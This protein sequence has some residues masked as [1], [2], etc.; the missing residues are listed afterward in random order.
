MAHVTL[1][2]ADDGSNTIHG[3]SG[4]EVIYGFDRNGPQSQ[5]SSISAIRVAT[6][7]TG[8]LFA[9]APPGDLN[10]LFLVQKTG[11][12]KILDLASGQVLATPFLDVSAQI[13]VTGERGLLGLAF[14]PDFAANGVF[15]VN[16]INTS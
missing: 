2:T 10:R 14:H 5:V 13:S 11:Q 1:V 15:Y 8:A 3:G 12:I 16:L 6:G 7:L 4:D 9:A